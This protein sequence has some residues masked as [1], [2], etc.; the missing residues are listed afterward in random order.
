VPR[1]DRLRRSVHDLS[2]LFRR[3]RREGW[4]LVLADLGIDLTTPAGELIATILAALAEFERR[5]IGLNTKQGLA[6]K[7][8]QGVRLGRPTA[9]TSKVRERIRRERAHGATWREIASSLN[10]LQVPTGHR[11]ARWYASTVRG[12]LLRSQ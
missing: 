6:I 2:G 7:R 11:G 10:R 4:Q 1:L 3:S 8:A 9:V 5:L 12:V